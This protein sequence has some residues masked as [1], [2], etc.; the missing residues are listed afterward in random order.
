MSSALRQGWRR[1]RASIAPGR[2]E[3]LSRVIPKGAR[4]L[5][6]GCGASS[7]LVHLRSRISRLDGIDAF[8]SALAEAQRS[9]A[10]D[11]LR[12]GRV[13]DLDELFDPRAYDVVVA[14]DLL[15]HLAED[16]GVRLL[17]SMSRIATR[18]VVVLTPNGFVHQDAIEGNPW[19]VHRSGWT[20]AQFRRRGFSVRGVHGLRVLRSEEAQFRFP[21]RRAWSLVSDLTAPIA[22]A[23]PSVAY[24]LL[25]TKDLS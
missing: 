5:D 18:R 8:S 6:V 17:D 13:Q 3:E 22:R 19:Q 4:V 1:V 7:P 12:E 20:P 14:V 10:Y 24:H 23:V 16:D 21:P 11:T 15:E 25:A 2:T 9:G